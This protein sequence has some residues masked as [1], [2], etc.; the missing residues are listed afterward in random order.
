MAVHRVFVYGTLKNGQPNHHWLGASKCLGR[1]HTLE[2]YP[3]IIA[4]QY[5]IPFLLYAPGQG[6]H[7]KGNLYTHTYIYINVK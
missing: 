3:L 7:V 5:N 4:T 2:M 6:N 1:G